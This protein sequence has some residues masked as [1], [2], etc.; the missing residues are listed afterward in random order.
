[1]IRIEGLGKRFDDGRWAVRDVDL[2]VESGAWLALIGASGSG[3]TTTLR[4][5]NRMVEPTEGR[6]EVDGRDVASVP[7]EVLRRGIGYVMQAV[8]LFPHWTVGENVAV[9]PRL[10]GWA[11]ARVAERVEEL[12][13]LVGLPPSSFRDRSPASLSGGQ[14]QR[15]G[16]ARALAAEPRILLMDEPF[17]A[18]DPVTRDLLQTEVRALHERLGLTTVMVTHDMAAALR[19]GDR[20]AVLDEGRVVRVGTPRELL[21]E[22][23]HPAVAA[24]LDAPR[25][26]AAL[27]AR[28]GSA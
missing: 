7:P 16:V 13:A 1:M 11:P 9:V 19:L 4:A 10:L 18:L 6:V 24:L 17:G 2:Q 5:V 23:G 3:K 15:V 21:A 28:L 14:R 25:R 27:L 20:I 8:G 22:P 26:H 12:L